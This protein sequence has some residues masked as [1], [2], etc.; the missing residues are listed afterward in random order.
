MA[1][2]FMKEFAGYEVEIVDIRNDFFGEQITVSGLITAKDM[3]AQTKERDLG[4]ILAIPCN[5]LRM[6]E[7]VFLDDL[8]VEDVENTL[9]VP[10]LIVKSSGF[11]LLEAMFGYE[12]ETEEE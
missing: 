10:V 12:V 8:S 6:G 11:A 4:N 1:D 3:I 9:Q 5:M 2:D 7:R